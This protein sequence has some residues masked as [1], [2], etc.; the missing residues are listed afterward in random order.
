MHEFLVTSVAFS[1]DGDF[2]VS[3]SD[4]DLLVKV[5]DTHTGQL[6]DTIQSI[7]IV[8]RLNYTS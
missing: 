5:W 1:P 8:V 7:Y 4:I 2:V 6:V 3:A